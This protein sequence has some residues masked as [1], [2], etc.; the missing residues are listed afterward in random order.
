[1]KQ[2]TTYDVPSLK[3][4]IAI[5]EYVSSYP[6]GRLISE[7]GEALKTPM[8]SIYRIVMVLEELGYLKRD[9]EDKRI[10]LTTEM[11]RIGQR[12][13]TEKS[14]VEESLDVMRGL[15]DQ[16][17]DTVLIGIREG[18]EVIVLEEAQGSRMFH[19][20]SKLGFR[21]NLHCSAPGKAIL[22]FLPEEER[23]MCLKKMKLVR[24]NSRTI[25]SC[26]R[27]RDE[28]LGAHRLGWALDRAEQFDGVYCIGAPVF[29]RT[30]YP[31]AA[32]WVTGLLM[33]IEENKIPEIGRKVRSAADSISGRMGWTKTK[34]GKTK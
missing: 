3:L 1:M 22:A 8:S 26:E 23:E 24:Y 20:V 18:L 34:E 5:L 28:L 15:R 9:A 16:V 17:T 19:F 10:C 13:I 27:L 21:L 31:V 25:V 6:H 29:D 32:I 33:D 7:I 30:G 14:L 11:L 12:A 2:K 4:G